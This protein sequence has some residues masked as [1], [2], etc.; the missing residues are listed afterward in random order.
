MEI[1]RAFWIH[2]FADDK[3]FAFLFGNKGTAAVGGGTAELY[4]GKTAVRVGET[5]SQTLHRSWPLEPLFLY[6]KGFGASHR[7][8]VQSSGMSHSEHRLTGRIFLP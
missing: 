8:Q 4:R 3:V 6:K 1:V 7:G 2:A 5:A